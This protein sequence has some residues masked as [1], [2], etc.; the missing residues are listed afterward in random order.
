MEKKEWIEMEKMS[1]PEAHTHHSP[2]APLASLSHWSTSPIITKMNLVRNK[3]KDKELYEESNSPLV[4]PVSVPRQ[5]ERVFVITAFTFQSYSQL[6]TWPR[7]CFWHLGSIH[8][9]SCLK[10]AWRIA[11]VQVNCCQHATRHG[12]PLTLTPFMSPRGMNQTRE[13][14]ISPAS[15]PRKCLTVGNLSF[16]RLSQNHIP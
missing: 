6:L 16:L 4:P 11:S 9:A 5:L 10:P 3:E 12:V 1:L 2:P 13:L 7:L 15:M 14:L 8:P